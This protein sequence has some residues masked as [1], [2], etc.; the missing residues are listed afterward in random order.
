MATDCVAT[1]ETWDDNA[2]KPLI[3]EYARARVAR[4][5]LRW[6]KYFW[7]F[8]NLVA[9]AA[10]AVLGLLGEASMI[11][12]TFAPLEEQCPPLWMRFGY[13][14]YGALLALSFVTMRHGKRVLR[15]LNISIP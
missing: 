13:L 6:V 7:G 1:S 10:A 11:L 15:D 9:S 3:I 2:K 14:I 4:W 5:D 12:V 8:F